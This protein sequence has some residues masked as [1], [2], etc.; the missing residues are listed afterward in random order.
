MQEKWKS[1]NI[2]T[3]TYK[4]D[5]LFVVK[6]FDE[7]EQELDDDFAITSGLLI[8]PFRMPFEQEINEWNAQLL[9]MSNLVEEWK[10]L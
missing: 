2:D 9:L 8:N 10:R 5:D 3:I 7:V 6:T 4:K 1:I